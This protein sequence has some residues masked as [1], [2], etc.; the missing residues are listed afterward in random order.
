MGASISISVK[1]NSQNISNNTS[2]VTVDVVVKWTSGSWN[3]TGECYGSLTI[4]GVT[5][6]YSGLTF[7]TGVT[8]SGSQT[9]MSKTV[10]VTHNYDGTK[11]L[12]CSASFYTG[13]SSSGTQTATASKALTMIP[14]ATT[15]TVSG[16]LSL[17]STI[18]I[19]TA[20]RASSNFTHNLYY[21]W[22]SQIID[23]QIATGVATSYS[24][25]IPKTLAEHIQAGTSGTMFLKCVTYNG[26]TAVGTKT[27]TLTITVPNTAEFQPS[28]QSISAVDANS[29]PLNRYVVS[30][31]KLKFTISA[32]GGY[33]SG[34]SNRNSYLTKA[35]VSVDGANYTVTLGQYASNTFEVTTNHLT[36]AGSL[37]AVVTVTDSRGRSSSKSFSYT[38][39]DYFAPEIKAFTAQRCLA[40][41]TLDDSGT[42]V[43][44]NAKITVASVNNLNAKSYKLVYE[45][46]GTEITLKS[47]TLSTYVDNAI[48]YNSF[49]NGITFS[50]DYVWPVRMYVYDSFNTDTPAAATVIVPT[51]GTFMDWRDNGKGFA[52]GKVST[53][54]GFECGWS[55]YDKFDTLIGNGLARY[56]GSGDT[57]IDPNTTFE[58]LI[59]T[60]KNT[61]TTGFWYV[62]TM[63]YSTKSDMANRSQFAMPYSSSSAP[64]MR[65]FY[66]GT[67][68]AWIDIETVVETGT[69]GIWTYKKYASGEAECWGRVEVTTNVSSAWGSLFTSGGI[70]ALNVAF[71]F[72]FADVPIVNTTLSG[73]SVGGMLMVS[74]N[75]AGGTTTTQTGYYEICRGSAVTGGNFI[76]NY[77][78]KGRWR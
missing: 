60:N 25:V 22:G 70:S 68:S 37:S 58:H 44:I 78:V 56:T 53:K 39:Y 57:A 59:V 47:G 28:V 73:N 67:W 42:Y 69:S 62:M 23:Q 8:T 74:G 7:N 4:D 9:I 35:V 48:S 51:E 29:L 72:T 1:Q 33:V 11:T 6:S 41:G 36:K 26:S 27:L 49:S 16:S 15:P 31:T 2:N 19:S 52:F 55:M 18:T 3:G 77:H 10:N 45:N 43:I 40:D 71:P 20:G 75:V 14:K 21:S 76:V 54:D 50:V 61:P 64:R 66:N 13:L 46:N 34:S 17:G 24:W 32:V 12:N 65:Y 30:K 63:F 5:Y 38:A